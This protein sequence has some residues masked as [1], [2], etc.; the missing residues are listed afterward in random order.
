M[1]EKRILKDLSLKGYNTF[2]V[3][4]R[5]KYFF[6]AIT[7][8]DLLWIIHQEEFKG[9]KMILGGGSNMLLTQD[10]DGLV[11]KISFKEKWIEKSDGDHTLVSVMAGENWHQF[12]LWTIENGLGGLENLSLIPGNVGT[13]PVQNIGAYG[14]EVKD[15]FHHLEALNMETG[16]FEIFRPEECNFGYR[17]SFFKEEEGKNKYIII[18]VFFCLTHTNHL[19]NTKYGAIEAELEK[20]GE[21]PSIESISKAVCNIRSSKLPNPVLL[22][23]SGSFFKNPV[24]PNAVYEKL[25]AEFPDIVAYPAGNDGYTKLAAGWLIEKAGWKGFRRGDAAVHEKQ[26]LVLVNHGKASGKEIEALATEIKES[27]KRT[28]AVNLEEE[29]NLI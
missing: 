29:I 1:N 8:D 4:A 22:G 5:A 9:K 3:E 23:N 16:E 7:V 6:E 25:K 19:L 15:T 12:V 14:V 24:V 18:R 27:I 17:Q 20:M 2:G 11:I 28:F 21:E 13:A 26:A 10:F